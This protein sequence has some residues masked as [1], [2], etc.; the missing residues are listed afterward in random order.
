[1]TKVDT[2]M[3]I[4][5]GFRARVWTVN[6]QVAGSSP[7]RGANNQTSFAL[8]ISFIIYLDRVLSLALIARCKNR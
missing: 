3:V 5:K 7:A 2:E 1:M 8:P 6:P 4:D